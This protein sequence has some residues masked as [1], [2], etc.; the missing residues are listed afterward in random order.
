MRSGLTP[1][2]ELDMLLDG[3][4]WMLVLTLLFCV[5]LVRYMQKRVN[6]KTNGLTRVT[7]VLL[8]IVALLILTWRR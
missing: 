2:P 1:V 7:W 8:G 4:R 5:G 6:L 3:T